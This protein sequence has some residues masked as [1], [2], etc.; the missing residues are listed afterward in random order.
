[1]GKPYVVAACLL[2]AL[3][4]ATTNAV[5]LGRRDLSES[6]V[7]DAAHAPA[8]AVAG[9]ADSVAQSV[10]EAVSKASDAVRCGANS[11]SV[12]CGGGGLGPVVRASSV[13][14]LSWRD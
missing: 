4:A 5:T 8:G 9:A 2:L 6:T 12:E 1:M 3:L 14:M 10:R 7:S 11:D 13:G